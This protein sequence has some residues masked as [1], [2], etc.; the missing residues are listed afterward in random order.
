MMRSRQR[1]LNNGYYQVLA[2]GIIAAINQT[3]LNL[4]QTLLD[5]GCGE[6][7][8]LNQL[9]DAAV[10]SEINLQLVGLD[11]SKAGVRLAAKRKLSAQLIVD[12]AYKIPLFENSVD[13][14]LSVF[15]PL[16]PNETARVLKTDGILIMV[17]PGEE[18]LTGLTAHIYEQHEPHEGNFKTTDEHPNFSLQQQIEIKSVVTV[19]GPDIFDLLTMTPYYW[20]CTAEQ[21][22]QLAALDQLITPIHFYLRVYK[23]NTSE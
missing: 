12:S 19:N 11:I 18:H 23:N 2:D 1:F 15:S 8:Y 10:N 17:G 13:T 4:E 16:C 5:I 6:G 3:H 22:Q 7:Y 14:A 21:Q 20:H 9:S